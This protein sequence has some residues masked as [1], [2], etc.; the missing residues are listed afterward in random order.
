[1]GELHDETVDDEPILHRNLTPETILVRHDNTPIFTGFEL[2]RIPSEGS[3]ASVGPPSGEWPPS[4]APEVRAQ[5]LQAA[6]VRSDRYALC[7][8]LRVL[9]ENSD[10]ETRHQ[11]L[12][13]LASGM[14]EDPT[15]RCEPSALDTR[16]SALLGESPPVPPPP[17]ARFW[18]EDQIVPFRGGH[19]R[20]VERLG[21]GGVGTTFKVV[22]LDRSRNEELGTYVAKVCHDE[23][24]G[25]R[26][27]SAYRL[28]RSHL[29]QHQS[30][31]GI[32]EVA[33]EWRE[34]EFTALMSW[35]EG[36]PLRDFVGVLPLFKDDLDEPSTEA[37]TLAW[38]R[39]MC[40]AL[41]VLHRNG[42]IH[43]DVSPGNLIVSGR[44]LVL[45]DYDFVS[46]F[47][48][49]IAAP[50]ALL[51]CSPSHQ[52]GQ[53]ASPS[54]DLYAL[55]ASFFHVMFEH[56]PFRHDGTLAKDRG[57]NREAVDAEQRAEYPTVAAFLDRATDPDP[58]RR[59]PSAAEALKVLTV[60]PP[61]SP[62][63][64]TAVP[65]GEEA[66]RREERVEW[67]RSLLQSY[68]GSRWGNQETR[69]L[70]SDFAEQTYVET[71]SR[72]RSTTTYGRAASGSSSCAV[73]LATA[74]QRCSSISCDG[75]AS[76]AASHP[77]AYW[78]VR[79]TTACAS[80]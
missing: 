17:P 15:D 22:Q 60:E 70:D 59:F 24:A 23:E 3:V 57:L 14:V 78:K 47:G 69:G 44:D 56:E 28:A 68:P 2:S 30:V 79:R 13:V 76:N 46:R 74:R 4:T 34:N 21:S 27:V 9:F 8:S 12:E 7:A 6:D 18:T 77:S 40:E 52:T 51:Y 10:D 35:V 61:V 11:T 49:P 45:T 63:T 36:S 42:L 73:M 37:L 39:A 33:S 54:D 50:G 75:S 67:L 19:Y 29:L 5:G 65:A 1:M 38:L 62:P 55:A 32:F 26:A 43:G 80:G 58:A 16:L 20:V 41:D 53:A 71:P 66:P 31:S 72:R 25:R 64:V 48:E